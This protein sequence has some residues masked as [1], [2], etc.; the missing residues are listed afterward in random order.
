[1]GGCSD[2]CHP[3]LCRGPEKQDRAIRTLGP[4]S[5]KVLIL[6]LALA[7]ALQVVQLLWSTVAS[8]RSPCRVDTKAWAQPRWPNRP[9]PFPQAGSRLALLQRQAGAMSRVGSRDSSNATNATIMLLR[10]EQMGLLWSGGPLSLQTAPCLSEKN[11]DLRSH[12]LLGP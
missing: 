9:T 2:T 12:L 3:G 5:G 1:M 4:G 6:V 11:S 10:G 8:P 7:L